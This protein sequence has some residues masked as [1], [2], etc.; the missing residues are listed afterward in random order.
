MSP[1]RTILF[2]LTG[3]CA[4]LCACGITSNVR[5]GAT[6][7]LDVVAPPD[8]SVALKEAADPFRSEL[9][10]RGTQTLTALS[11]EAGATPIASQEPALGI[12][13]NNLADSDPGVRSL[14]ARALGSFG[15][16][17]DALQIAALLAD[18][19]PQVRTEAARALQRL[20]DPN[21]VDAL[22][23][24]LSQDAEPDPQVRLEVA[25]AL[26]QYRQTKVVDA[27]IASLDDEHLGVNRRTQASLRTLTGQDFGL[28]RASWQAWYRA[29]PSAQQVFAASTGYVHPAYTRARKWYE[30]I[31]L[32]PQPPNETPG[33]PAGMLR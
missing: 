26:A 17:T 31:P 18:T 10:Y 22:L 8:P 7:I 13:R 27:L 5:P 9:R 32:V 28:S 4:F 20:H 2:L 15:D 24:R 1:R 6:S 21:V 16:E 29:I 3:S 19:D 23:A 33:T 11:L 30:Y 25:T 14:A 12:L